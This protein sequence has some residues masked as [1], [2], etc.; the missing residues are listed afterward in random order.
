MDTEMTETT[1]VKRREHTYINTTKANIFTGK[2]CVKP[3]GEVKLLADE[4]A[5]FEGLKRP[6]DIKDA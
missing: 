5:I 3:G 6:Q 1:E 2:H 4:A